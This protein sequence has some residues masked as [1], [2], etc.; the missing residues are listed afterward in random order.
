MLRAS[1]TKVVGQFGMLSVQN[2]REHTASRRVG[3]KRRLSLFASSWD[4]AHWLPLSVTFLLCVSQVHAVLN[5]VRIARFSERLNSNFPCGNADGDG[6]EVYGTTED[7]SESL[8]VYQHQ[9]HNQ[10]Q[11]VNTGAL[12]E[13]HPWEY[14]DGDGDGAME[15]VGGPCGGAVVILEAPSPG[16]LPSDSV[17]GARP[18]AVAGYC[19]PRFFDL[20]RDERLELAWQVEGYGIYLYE[21]SGDNRYDSAAVLEDTAR[22]CGADGDF[23]AGDLD[24]DSLIELVVGNHNL[25][26]AGFLHVFEATGQDNEYVLVARCTL[27]LRTVYNVCIAN[28]MDHNGR[29][30]FLAIGVFSPGMK[31]MMYEADTAAN[32]YRR[33]WEQARPDFNQG[34]YGNPFSVGD[35]EGDGTQ[36]FA[37][38]GGGCIALYKC[39]GLHS[40]EQVWLF[41]STETYVRLFDINS[42]GR[43]EVIFDGPQGTEIWEDTEGLAAVEMAQP[44]LGTRVSIL[45]TVLRLGSTALFSDVPTDAVVEIHGIDGRLVRRQPQARQSD[46]TWNLRDQ[47]GSLV[48]AGTYFAVIRNKGKATSLKLCVVR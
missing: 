29:P 38:S 22:Y 24:G 27:E 44:R 25:V 1:A 7:P 14:G 20:D 9:G 34:W 5:M 19:H 12:V 41:D 18:H 11:R 3:R 4:S 6:F 21:N 10:F 37:V 2:C 47:T 28:D 39:T 36:E 43:A 46:W 45:P 16:A 31:L 42:D 8:I 32:R 15:V 40:F 33:V 13:G 48:S 35:V 23:D 17:W 26:S 30:E